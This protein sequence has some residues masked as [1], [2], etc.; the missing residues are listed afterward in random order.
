MRSVS[1]GITRQPD[2][3]NCSSTNISRKLTGTQACEL[4]ITFENVV[5]SRN[6]LD[7]VIVVGLSVGRSA[8]VDD[9]CEMVDEDDG[10]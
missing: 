8:S 4:V 5:C 7:T 1:I 3:Q 2:F 9:K 10:F 6:D